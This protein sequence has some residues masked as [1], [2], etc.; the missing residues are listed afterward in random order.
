MTSVESCLYPIL[1][2]LPARSADIEVDSGQG[3]CYLLHFDRPY[4][5]AAHYTGWSIDIVERIRRHREG[6]G[7]RL[8]EVVTQAGIDFVV[9]RVWIGAD[10]VKER[11]LKRS[12][13]ASRYCPVCK[14]R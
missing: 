5:H 6:N 3:G 2:V 8:V 12:G 9:A 13:G 4:R 1:M 11:R 14:S 7:A 10:R